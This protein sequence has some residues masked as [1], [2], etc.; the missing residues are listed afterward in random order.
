MWLLIQVVA[1]I[2]AFVAYRRTARL[3]VIERRW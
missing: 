3:E 1:V 2:L